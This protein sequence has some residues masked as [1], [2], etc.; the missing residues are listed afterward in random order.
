MLTLLRPAIPTASASRHCTI[1][2][3][4]LVAVSARRSRQV[5]SVPRSMQWPEKPPDA[6][7]KPELEV[8]EGN[9]KTAEQERSRAKPSRQR[10]FPTIG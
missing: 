8:C 5:P 10:N 4:A 9:W 7:D 6:S 2:G 1:M 3:R